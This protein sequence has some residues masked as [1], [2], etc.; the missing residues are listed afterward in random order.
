MMETAEFIR[1]LEDARPSVFRVAEWI[2]RGSSVVPSR[3]VIIPAL[4][5]FAGTDDGDLF[6]QDKIGVRLK[7]EVKH[8]K[9][10]YFTCADDFNFS[11]MIVSNVNT[12]RRQWGTVIAY[13]IVNTPMTHAAV[14]LFEHQDKWTTKSIYAKNTKK[15]EQFFLC[16][17][18]HAIFVKIT[19]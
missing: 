17:K 16:P 11:D 5:Y 1:S 4:D 13:V 12:V 3:T 6:V 2:N 18:E 15:V 19:G 7:V 14:I 9:N 8:K 10:D